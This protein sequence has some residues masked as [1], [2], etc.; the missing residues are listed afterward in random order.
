MFEWAYDMNGSKVPFIK[1][2]YIPTATAVEKG[3][4]IDFTPGTGVVVLSDSDDADDAYAGVAMYAHEASSG[5][6]IAVSVSPTAVYRH[7]CTEVI[8]A[9]GGSTTTFVCSTLVPT[10]DNLWIGGYLEVVTCAADSSMIGKRIYIT[11]STGTGGT[12]TFDTQP[13]A[14]ASGDTA[15]LCPGPLALYTTGWN[16]D[17]DAVDVDWA[18]NGTTG[19]SLVL[20]DVNPSA[21]EAYFMLRLHK[22]GNG[23]AS[24]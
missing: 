7:N 4:I 20:V 9:T 19:E 10:T 24:L 5:T 3:E 12:I 18:Q 14:F 1:R 15:R 8:T 11:D 17:D 21:M 16:L 22:F 2:L 13:A 6:E 23:P